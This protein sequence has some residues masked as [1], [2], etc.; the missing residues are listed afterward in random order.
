MMSGKRRSAFGLLAISSMLVAGAL[1]VA[2]EPQAKSEARPVAPVR[3]WDEITRDMTP[4][5]TPRD[6]YEKVR[7]FLGPDTPDP[8]TDPEG[9]AEAFR[10]HYGLSLAPYP[11]D[12]LPMGLSL[13]TFPDGKTVGLRGDC[14]ACHGGS[15][16]GQSYVGLGNT[17][18]NL[19][20]WIVDFAKASGRQIPGFPFTVNSVRGLNN[21][22]QFTVLLMGQRNPDMSRRRLP[23]LTGAYMPEADTPAWWHLKKK[24]TKYYVGYTSAES[25]RSNMAFLM[26]ASRYGPEDFADKE[27]MF[28]EMQEFFQSLE[29]PK[30]PFPIDQDKADRGR[31]V[32]EKNCARCHGTYG[33]DWTYP[34]R[35]VPLDLIGTD[36]TLAQALTSRYIDYYNSS[37]FADPYPFRE[38][39]DGYQAPPLDGIWATAPYLHNG[40][41]PTLAHMLDSSSRPSKYRRPPSTDFEHYDTKRVGWKFEE[42]GPD[43]EVDPKS[44]L[45]FDSTRFGLDNGG[46]TFGDELSDEERWEVIEYLKT[47]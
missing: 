1:V 37:F 21:A 24:K 5:T 36:P 43:D 33:E 41:V 46:H 26:S 2:D 18:L 39:I 20:A 15:I 10:R 25:H 30:Y 6:V 11:N 47:L 19:E 34:N 3:G 42:V 35:I 4:A 13:G 14:L 8:E 40:S 12:G 28:R 44:K 31:V 32:F 23:Y 38:K 45:I 7:P 27:P 16:G 17:Q 9:Y 29:A 22:W